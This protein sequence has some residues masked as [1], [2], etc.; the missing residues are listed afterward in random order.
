[1][2]LVNWQLAIGSLAL[3]PLLV[4][5]VAMMVTRLPPRLRDI[6]KRRQMTDAGITEKFGGVHVVRSCSRE[7]SELNRFVRTGH[8][9]FRQEARA[10]WTRMK[11]SLVWEAIL[12]IGLVV[13]LLLGGWQVLSVKLTV[14]DLTMML[15]YGLHCWA[16][17]CSCWWLLV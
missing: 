16:H 14:G 3:L 11:F 4:L 7:Q 10:W 12:P 2:A 9:I 13:L 1:M 17:S 15:V 8:L 5:A 6:H